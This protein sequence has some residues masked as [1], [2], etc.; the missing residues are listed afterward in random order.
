[1][2]AAV[3][4]GKKWGREHGRR[5]TT[6]KVLVTCR[7]SA[8]NY[9]APDYVAAGKA[10]PG[11]MAARSKGMAQLDCEGQSDDVICQ[12]SKAGAQCAGREGTKRRK[13]DWRGVPCGRCVLA[14]QQPQQQP[15]M[16]RWLSSNP[17]LP[18]T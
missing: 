1:M 11:P 12:G 5:R 7:W 6:T 16:V 9:D 15:L 18:E 4:H 17:G 8:V 2:S 13:A 14:H 3:R 10:A